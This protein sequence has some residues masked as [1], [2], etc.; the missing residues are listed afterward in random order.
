MMVRIAHGAAQILIWTAIILL[1][2]LPALFGSASSVAAVLLALLLA[3]LLLWSGRW[4]SIADQPAMLI[5]PAVF[6]ALVLSY[7]I[8]ARDPGNVVYAASF[9]AL[10]FAIPVY[11]AARRWAVDRPALLVAALCLAGTLICA[12]VAAND[13]FVRN[14]PRASGY[15]MG[16]NLLARM[17]IM[18]GFTGLAGLFV[19]RSPWRFLLYLGPAFALVVM[20]LTGTRGAALAI[21]PFLLVL[22]ACLWVERRYRRQLWA[23]AAIGAALLALLALSGRF[24]SILTVVAEVLHSGAAASDSASAQRLEML[25]AAFKAFKAAPWFGYGWANLAP[26]AAPFI[27]MSAY[28]GDHDPY[29]QFHND[30]ANFAVASGFVGILCWLALL[31]APIVGVLA[32]PRDGLFR[33]R[34][35]CCLQLSAGYIA[36]GLTDL[37]FGYDLPTT[38]YA[39]LTALVLGA[40]R[41]EP[42]AAIA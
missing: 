16:G 20:A 25:Y 11:L 28:G 40:F 6:A 1:L 31:A 21:P 10:P 29:F 3:P 30:L 35:Y 5:F 32:T 37:N 34:L 19:S 2:L 26:A 8:T 18:L 38:L 17:A 23:L 33:A 15:F 4:R 27:D 12:L 41:D 7:A 36:L 22:A 9:L 39:F 13:V 24:G 42:V 14:M